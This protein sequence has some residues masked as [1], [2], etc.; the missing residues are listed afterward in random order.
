VNVYNQIGTVKQASLSQ[1]PVSRPFGNYLTRDPPRKSAIA[2]ASPFRPH[3]RTHF[4]PIRQK[5]FH[6]RVE[7]PSFFSAATS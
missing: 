3:R 1:L 2:K 4:R 7:V 5:E 6:H